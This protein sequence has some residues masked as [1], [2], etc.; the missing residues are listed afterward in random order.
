MTRRDRKSHFLATAMLVPIERPAALSKSLIARAVSS[1]GTPNKFGFVRAS[2]V[3]VVMFVLRF[4]SVCDFSR[5][6]E[7]D[8]ASDE[9]HG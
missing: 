6:K 8:G 4:V 5:S 1:E 7:G 9:H 3:F 2:P